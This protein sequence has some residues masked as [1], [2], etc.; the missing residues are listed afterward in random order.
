MQ[1]IAEMFRD[2]AMKKLLKEFDL[3]KLSDHIIIFALIIFVIVSVLLIALFFMHLSLQNVIADSNELLLED[4]AQLQET[5]QDLQETVGILSALPQDQSAV[6]ERLDSIDE[7]LG[8]IESSIGET[9]GLLEEHYSTQG[10]LVTDPVLVEEIQDIKTSINQLFLIVSW[11]IGSLSII[12]AIVLTLVMN[13]RPQRNN[14][15][16]ENFP[17]A[18]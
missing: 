14:L 1:H 4:V 3:Y 18:R 9:A 13:T 8:I 11:L 7:N 16:P 5:T 6:E 12:I 2:R 15:L 17:P 10:I